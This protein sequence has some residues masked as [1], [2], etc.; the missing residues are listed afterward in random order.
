MTQ[1]RMTRT[2]LLL[3]AMVLVFTAVY[4]AGAILAPAAFAV[5]IIAVVW[6]LQS[7][8]QARMPTPLAAAI[9]ILV[10][11]A[12]IAVLVYLVVWGFGLVFQWLL[13]N[14]ARFQSL[15]AQAMEWLGEHGIA[16]KN[17]MTENYNPGWVLGPLREVGGRS[18]RLVSFVI[19][20]FAFVALGLLEVEVVRRNI[21]H[22]GDNEFRQSLLRVGRNIATKFQKYML[23]RTVMSILT[24]LIVWCFALVAGIELAT[25]W[26]VIAFV[27]NYIPFLGPL[28]ATIFP[29]I[30]ALAQFESWQL[31]IAIF[32]FLNVVQFITG[33]YI[34]PRMAGAALSISPFVVLF[35][36]FFW[37]FLWGI[38]GA[39]IGVPIVIAVIAVCDEN[40]SARW[41]AILLSGRD[42][43]AG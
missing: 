34:E 8:L 29:T 10:T 27:F 22:L 17:F 3:G 32:A 23:V 20:V 42:R 6:P 30:C 4:F 12:A 39:F 21:Q 18:Y 41:F 9:T 7:A 31:A 24:G 16:V 15:Y 40:E 2:S 36:V 19:I 1:D 5:F 37:S 35:A 33:S 43:K 13:A 14:T 38:P 11:V 28:F 25:A 26:G